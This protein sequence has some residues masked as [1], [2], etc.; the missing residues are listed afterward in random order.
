MLVP[1]LDN[2]KHYWIGDD[3]VQK[4][5]RHGKGWLETHPER[6]RI[7]YR[8]LK[9]Q[10]SLAK[11]ALVRLIVEE[12]GEVEEQSEVEER[13]E[14]EEQ[15]EEVE[16]GEDMA[17]TAMEEN[18]IV[19]KDCHRLH[20]LR[21]QA[22]RTELH[23]SGARRVLDLGCGEGKLIKL[24]L[25]DRQFERIVGVDVSYRVLELAQRRL[26]LD[27]LPSLQKDRV[28]LLHG[29][30]TYRDRRLEGFDAAAVVEVIEHLDPPRLAAFERVLFEFA[31]P[32]T[33]VMTTPNAE[34]NVKYGTLQAGTFRHKDHRF[35]W[36][37]AE[38]ESWAKR[39][40]P[41][42]GYEVRFRAVGPEDE[43]VGAP[44]QMGVFE[45]SKGI[46]DEDIGS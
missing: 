25:Q 31:R 14:V 8:Y 37:R 18:G 38:F 19:S 45:K 17:V 22:V 11:D 29:A 24:L 7:A 28:V 5:L 15:G 13:G 16:K 42:F 23:D 21:L 46:L 20:D 30:L 40:A 12:Q 26:H 32:A 34:Y 39:V 27:R 43:I 2:D 3:E 44:S 1:V 33:I 35:E 4:L 41:R 10:R 36:T 6:E 9:N